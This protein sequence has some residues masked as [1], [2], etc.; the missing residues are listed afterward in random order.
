M[1][2][3]N[4]KSSQFSC[5]WWK[6][7][8][9]LCHQSYTAFYGVNQM[10]RYNLYCG[11]SASWC[12]RTGEVCEVLWDFWV[13]FSLFHKISESAQLRTAQKQNW[14]DSELQKKQQWGRGEK[15]THQ[16]AS[17]N[18]QRGPG[19]LSAHG[20]LKAPLWWCWADHILQGGP[21][22]AHTVFC[23]LDCLQQ[24]WCQAWRSLIPSVNQ[25]T[26]PFLTYPSVSTPHCNRRE[27]T[28]IRAEQDE[29]MVY[30]LL[31]FYF[32]YGKNP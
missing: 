5:K 2:T 31:F 13:Q 14:T 22:Q 20:F 26:A 16:R 28:H 12:P 24:R 3:N 32:H 10:H 9:P 19:Q 7:F 29:W 6:M 4:M 11:F 25:N 18:P 27:N 21:L 23:S 15:T 17:A 1:H 8:L 30:Y